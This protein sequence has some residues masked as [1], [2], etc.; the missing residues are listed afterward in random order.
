MIRSYDI[1]VPGGQSQAATRSA[2]AAGDA[3]HAPCNTLHHYRIK[4]AIYT[5]NSSIN[6]KK[7]KGQRWLIGEI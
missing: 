3:D 5:S 2:G 7:C 1:V 4:T 6:I